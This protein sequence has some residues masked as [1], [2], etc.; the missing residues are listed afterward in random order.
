MGFKCSLWR[1]SP[2]LS[3]STPTCIF[4]FTDT[5]CPSFSMLYH[6]LWLRLIWFLDFWLTTL[7]KPRFES[8][9]TYSSFQMLIELAIAIIL[10][11]ISCERTLGIKLLEF[12]FFSYFWFVVTLSKLLPCALVCSFLLSFLLFNNFAE[13]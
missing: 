8:V 12:V 4:A 6:F 7:Y 2:Y 10:R 3:V 5:C 9:S 13:I 1:L 11:L